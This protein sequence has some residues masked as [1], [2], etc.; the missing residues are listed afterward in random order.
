MGRVQW[1]GNVLS[2]SSSSNDAQGFSSLFLGKIQRVSCYKTHPHFTREGSSLWR[3]NVACP[4]EPATERRHPLLLSVKFKYSAT[5]QGRKEKA[6]EK[7]IILM[8]IEDNNIF[9]LSGSRQLG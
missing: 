8:H 3:G 9:L 1:T 7:E 2:R 4:R 5:S 6:L